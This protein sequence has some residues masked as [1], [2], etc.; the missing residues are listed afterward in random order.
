MVAMRPRQRPYTPSRL[1]D[2]PAIVDVEHRPVAL[3]A[4]LPTAAGFSDTWAD[5]TA[6][7]PTLGKLWPAN[8]SA[9]RVRPDGRGWHI[10]SLGEWEAAGMAL[11]DG[12]AGPEAIAG[13]ILSRPAS[14]RPRRQPTRRHRMGADS[15]AWAGAALPALS[16]SRP[17]ATYSRPRAGPRPSA[18]RWWWPFYLL[19]CGPFLVLS[20]VRWPSGVI[21]RTL[22]VVAVAIGVLVTAA[23]VVERQQHSGPEVPAQVQPAAAGSGPGTGEGAETQPSGGAIPTQ[24]V[25]A[26]PAGVWV[27]V[28]NTG[29]Q[30]VYL[31]RQPDWSNKWVAWSEGAKL[32]VL[33]AGVSSM[34]APGASGAGWLQVRDPEGRVGYVPEQYVVL[35]PSP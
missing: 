28:A 31:R 4:D 35:A 23:L 3:D 17:S 29:G 15:L 22:L 34:G 32:Q 5:Y 10:T 24:D 25:S 18:L 27:M 21:P 12:P 16:D 20:R 30:G 7:R 2:E 14:R 1:L 26:A 8:A 11:G 33:A 19:L 9:G 13:A 6:A